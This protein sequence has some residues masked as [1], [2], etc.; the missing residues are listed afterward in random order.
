MDKRAQF[1]L[2]FGSA[3]VGRL[4]NFA[5]Y[6]GGL[7]RHEHEFESLKGKR[8]AIVLGTAN[9]ANL[10]DLAISEAQ[11]QFVR[12]H[13]A[14]EV[15]EIQT[16]QFWEYERVLHKYLEPSDILLLQGGGNMG[17]LYYWF[18]LERCAIVESFPENRTILFPQ[19]ISYSS[20]VSPLLSYA[21]KAYRGCRDLHMFARERISADRMKQEFPFTDVE[22]VP[23]IVLTLDPTPLIPRDCKRC[24]LTLVLRDDK[25]RSLSN[26]DWETLN[27][28][29]HRSGMPVRHA[30]TVLADQVVD[31]PGRTR[32]LSDILT[33]F[34]ASQ[35][36]I[37]DRL[38]GM[39]FA[40]ITGT[41]CVVLSNSN[42]KIKGVYEWIR[43]LPYIKFITNPL[44]ARHALEEVV[45][46]DAFYPR[47]FIERK[48][49]ALSELLK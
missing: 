39:I 49:T 31:I 45:A 9:Y 43:E 20:Q 5:Q 7:K 15:A 22:L 42:H 12:R 32:L 23:D 38:H 35:A 44:Q 1:K 18:E 14:G 37:T 21:R 26:D 13:F 19:T 41:P 8:K 29:A 17:D 2:Q 40:A 46:A 36:V 6:M 47:Q 3:R 33:V 25:E 34:A 16:S 11:M 30:D 10:G 24:G 27:A 48:F 28:V 4:S